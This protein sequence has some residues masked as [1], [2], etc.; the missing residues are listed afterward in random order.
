[1]KICPICS[2]PHSQK[3]KHCCKCNY[4]LRKD[5]ILAA[6]KKYQSKDPQLKRERFTSW[7]HRNK[8]HL[9]KKQRDRMKVDP[10]YKLIRYMRTRFWVALN[11]IAK[12]QKTKDILGCSVEDWKN[13]LAS[14]FTEGMNWGNYGRWHVDHIKPCALFDFNDPNQQAECFHYTNTQPLWSEDNLKK[15]AKYIVV[16]VPVV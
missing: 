2:T 9:N 1:M 10:K 14:K 8:E 7:R 4:K 6:V 12:S 5:K 3:S 13:H 11:G 16:A 15:N